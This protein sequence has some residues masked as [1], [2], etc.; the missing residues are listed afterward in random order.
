MPSELSKD[1]RD[2]MVASIKRFAREELDADWGDLKA[3]LLLD[4]FLHEIA[5]SVYN[6][7]VADAQAHMQ[8]RVEEVSVNVGQKEFGY[9]RR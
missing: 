3:G 2:R 9:W 6:Q 7:A 5:P 4:F 1:T 8:Q